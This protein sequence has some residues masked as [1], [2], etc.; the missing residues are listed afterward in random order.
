[1]SLNW[2]NTLNKMS[3]ATSFFDYGT[4]YNIKNNKKVLD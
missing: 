1:M 2:G 3:D 4:K